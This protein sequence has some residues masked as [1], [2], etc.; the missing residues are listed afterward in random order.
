MRGELARRARA[1]V[2]RRTL[3]VQWQLVLIDNALRQAVGLDVAGVDVV[4]LDIH[5]P[6]SE[7]GGA[8]VEVNAGPGL[9]MHLEPSAGLPRP[10]G[11]AIAELLF[12]HGENGRIPVAC[13]TGTN[14]ND[15]KMKHINPIYLYKIH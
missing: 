12:P 5:R 3:D 8:I 15:I 14:D 6:L 10:V 9:R 2:V 7:T 13:V 11:E 4:C 1:D